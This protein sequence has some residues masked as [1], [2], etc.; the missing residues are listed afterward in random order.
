MTNEINIVKKSFDR[1]NGLTRTRILMRELLNIANNLGPE[2]TDI[3]PDRFAAYKEAL[4]TETQ[5]L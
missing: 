5:N 1:S 3:V 4:Y 2:S